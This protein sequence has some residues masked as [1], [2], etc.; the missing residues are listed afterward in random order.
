[1]N[2][3]DRDLHNFDD[4]IFQKVA[5][6]NRAIPICSGETGSGNFQVFLEITSFENGKVVEMRGARD[7]ASRTWA[8]VLLKLV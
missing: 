5:P 4:T 1:M 8:M 6:P 3:G 2:L 7:I